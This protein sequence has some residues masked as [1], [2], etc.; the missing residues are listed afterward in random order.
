MVSDAVKSAAAAAFS[1]NWWFVA[2]CLQTAAIC[3][4]KSSSTGCLGYF[5][6]Q[7]AWHFRD[8]AAQRWKEL[9]SRS[10]HKHTT[11]NA[12]TDSLSVCQIPQSSKGNQGQMREA[13]EWWWTACRRSWS[14]YK[15]PQ[16]HS[17]EFVCF[18]L[19]AFS[20]PKFW[21]KECLPLVPLT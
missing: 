17:E 8:A 13:S 6:L 10:V 15:V 3:W 20:L 9:M 7:S 14:Y 18:I 19:F 16:Q 4:N 12:H 5:Y 11:Q 21:W 1:S 2:R